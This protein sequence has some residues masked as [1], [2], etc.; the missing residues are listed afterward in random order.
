[1]TWE[2][3]V[4]QSILRP[5]RKD[6]RPEG[7]LSRAYSERLTMSG[8]SAFYCVVKSGTGGNVE[9]ASRPNQ[10]ATLRWADEFGNSIAPFFTSR[11]SGCPFLKK[12][13]GWLLKSYPVSFVVAVIL[14]D[15]K[16][17]TSFYTIDPLSMERFIRLARCSSS[18]S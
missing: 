7:R 15:I 13:H 1:M 8:A 10:W 17:E 6:R 5:A 9:F 14:A 12:M 2:E 18:R 3:F 4:L 16:Q 11:E